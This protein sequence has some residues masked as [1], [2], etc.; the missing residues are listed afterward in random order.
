MPQ[1]VFN[2]DGF[3]PLYELAGTAMTDQD[4]VEVLVRPMAESDI[5]ALDW[6]ILTTAE[7]NCRTRHGLAFDGIGI[8]RAFDRR[9]G[10]VVSHYIARPL[11]LLDVIIQHGH[12]MGI[13]VYG[14]VR[15]NHALSPERLATVPGPV[16]FCHYNSIKKDFRQFSFH[17]YLAEIFEDLLAKGVDG[18]SLDFERKAPFYPPGTPE[19]QR[20]EGCLWFLRR[21]RDL[22]D[23]P[24]IVRVAHEPEKGRPQGQD[25]CA[26]MAEGLV[27]VVVPGTHNHEPDGLDWGFDA[28]LEAARASPRPC[29]VWPQIW[30]TGAG[31]QDN[32]VD[33]THPPGAVL[34]RVRDILARG[35]DGVYFF[36]FCCYHGEGRLFRDEAQ[37]G[38]FR[39]LAECAT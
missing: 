15:L 24:I 31:W 4:A 28:L 13:K 16:N 6:C 22:T 35:A 8:D 20:L 10:A 29:Q 19:D 2:N 5:T 7:H 34:D 3:G 32:A 9:V 39:R 14:N 33:S 11:D 12:E 18:I 17:Q 1:F 25:P 36:N 26:W 27:D 37:G 21:M 38:L 23:K 30:P